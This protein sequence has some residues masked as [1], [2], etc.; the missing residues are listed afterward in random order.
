MDYLLHT[1]LKC[2]HIVNNSVASILNFGEYDKQQTL[3]ETIKYVDF[4]DLLNYI[5]FSNEQLLDL[6]DT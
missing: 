2:K 6:V 5:N 4:K 3:A 1:N